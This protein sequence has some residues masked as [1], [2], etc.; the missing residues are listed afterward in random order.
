VFGSNIKAS[1]NTFS[2]KIL[3]RSVKGT[4]YLDCQKKLYFSPHFS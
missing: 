3:K 1:S 4:W 2:P